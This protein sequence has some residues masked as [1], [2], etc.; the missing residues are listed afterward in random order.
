MTLSLGSQL[1]NQSLRVVRVVKPIRDN[2]IIFKRV[3]FASMNG[4]QH[5]EG[6]LR[7]TQR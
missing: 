7:G 2:H 3:N 5:G 6:G 4:S 1:K